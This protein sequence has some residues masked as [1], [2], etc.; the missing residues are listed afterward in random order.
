MSL[1]ENPLLQHTKARGFLPPS[2]SSTGR[3]RISP[4]TTKTLIRFVLM[5]AQSSGRIP[6]T[7]LGWCSCFGISGV[8]MMLIQELRAKEKPLFVATQTRAVRMTV[9]LVSRYRALGEAAHDGNLL[10]LILKYYDD[11]SETKLGNQRQSSISR[12]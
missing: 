8:L 1:N 2:L 12:N 11:S 10:C 7:P 3:C 5:T 9:P 6:R 4:T